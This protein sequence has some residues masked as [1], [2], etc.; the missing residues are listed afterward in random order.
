MKK[1]KLKKETIATL[2]N[3]QM[4]VVHGGLFKSRFLCRKK[5]TMPPG[6]PSERTCFC[7]ITPSEDHSSDQSMG[8]GPI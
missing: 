5:Q 8:D 1:L 4:E 3:H 2:S 6:C 7:G